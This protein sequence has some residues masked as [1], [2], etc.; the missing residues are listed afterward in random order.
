M[1]YFTETGWTLPDMAA[2]SEDFD[3]DY[4]QSKYERKIAKLIR[5]A[6]KHDYKEARDEYDSWWSAI[7][8]LNKEDHYISAIIRVAGLRPAGDRL[9]LFGTALAVVTCFLLVTFLCI[10]YQ[11]HLPRYLETKDDRRFIFWLGGVCVVFAYV[12]LQFILGRKKVDNFLSKAI[13]AF[14]RLSQRR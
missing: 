7:R 10:K 1:L 3:R 13:E 4:D 8:F 2:V 14:V 9:R 12:L 6:A 11:V 5:K